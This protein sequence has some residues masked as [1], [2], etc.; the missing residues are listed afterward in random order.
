MAH[1]D[2]Q[3]PR[4]TG[5][6]LQWV[7]RGERRNVARMQK[8][9][10]EAASAP[11]PAPPPPPPAPESSVVESGVCVPERRIGIK[12][13]LAQKP[14]GHLLLSH[15]DWK[16][17]EGTYGC[18]GSPSAPYPT[19]EEILR[20][21]PAAGIGSGPPGPP[22]YVSCKPRVVPNSTWTTLGGTGFRELAS[23]PSKDTNRIHNSSRP[24][25]A[26]VNEAALQLLASRSVSP[27][28]MAS[29]RRAGRRR[30]QRRRRSAGVSAIIPLGGSR[31]S[32]VSDISAMLS[33]R[34]ATTKT[35]SEEL[36]GNVLKDP[37]LMERG[38]GASAAPPRAATPVPLPTTSKHVTAA[39]GGLRAST[40]APQHVA[41]GAVAQHR[42]AV[43]TADRGGIVKA[44]GAAA[45][46]R[47]DGDGE[48]PP[49]APLP[50]LRR[51]R[52]RPANHPDRHGR[53]G[54]TQPP[55]VPS[56]IEGPINVPLAPA[57][58][59]HGVA[60]LHSRR[61]APHPLRP[62]GGLACG[63]IVL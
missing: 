36:L 22:A 28:P 30:G 62:L 26:P 24:P 25:P 52:Y 16:L 57:F 47:A 29:K 9:R 11:P 3:D 31:D 7:R 48:R 42:G 8:L 10:D 1:L 27:S 44:P 33:G 51:S 39:P 61:R 53:L 12:C 23:V 55:P 59:T 34:A 49:T 14:E 41:Y 38:V 6:E 50:K 56:S 4:V 63:T 54:L 40:P 17:Q 18:W 46:G 19:A 13:N 5:H 45:P 60:T 20:I 2:A 43:E 15:W 58:V 37:R 21:P 32:E 35:F